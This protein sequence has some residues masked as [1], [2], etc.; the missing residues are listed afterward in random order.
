MPAGTYTVRIGGQSVSGLRVDG[1]KT[2][3]APL[4]DIRERQGIVTGS[5]RSALGRPLDKA[6][7]TL[8]GPEGADSSTK[9]ATTGSDG[10]FQFSNLLGG[11]YTVST[12]EVSQALVVVGSEPVPR[13]ACRSSTG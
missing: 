10:T 3:E 9:Q 1:V 2:V 11:K 5:V 4:I 7:V 13:H 6:A 8:V 12:G